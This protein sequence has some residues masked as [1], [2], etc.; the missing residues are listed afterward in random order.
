MAARRALL[1]RLPLDDGQRLEILATRRGVTAEQL[2]EHIVLTWID[3]PGRGELVDALLRPK[4]KDPSR[5]RSAPMP[6]QLQLVDLAAASQCRAQR[7]C[8]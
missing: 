7:P 2:V 4:R 5:G 8:R 3:G 6:G 1:L